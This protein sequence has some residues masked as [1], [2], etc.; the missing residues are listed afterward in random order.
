MWLDKNNNIIENPNAPKLTGNMQ[1]IK[2]N[3]EGLVNAKGEVV[4]PCEEGIE[5]VGEY[6]VHPA[7]SKNA[8]V[9]GG[10]TTSNGENIR[11]SFVGAVTVLATHVC[12]TSASIMAMMLRAFRSVWSLLF[13]TLPVTLF[14]VSLSQPKKNLVNGIESTH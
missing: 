6:I 2:L 7:F 8:E 12:S 10:W 13:S 5:T 11:S 1:P 4:T 9:G 3:A 14:L